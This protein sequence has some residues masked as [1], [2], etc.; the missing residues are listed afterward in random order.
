MGNT[1]SA[2]PKQLL[3]NVWPGTSPIMEGRRD[4]LLCMGTTVVKGWWNGWGHSRSINEVFKR[5]HEITQQ[6][7]GELSFHTVYFESKLNPADAPS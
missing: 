4:T 7:T 6:S 3:S 1:I 2:G 5:I